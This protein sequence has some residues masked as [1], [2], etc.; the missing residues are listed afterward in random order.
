MQQGGGSG[1]G[2]GRGC[3]RWRSLGLHLALF[4]WARGWGY[5]VVGG[6]FDHYS[7]SDLDRRGAWSGRDDDWRVVDPDGFRGGE[8]ERL[9]KVTYSGQGELGLGKDGGA[10]IFLQLQP[11]REEGPDHSV[12]LC[13]WVVCGGHGSDEGADIAISLDGF[14]NIR[15]DNVGV[16]RDRG[17][18]KG[19]P[20]IEGTV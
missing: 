9:G 18:A 13:D 11:E 7:V 14:P 8:G 2:S 1:R 16:G 5:S 10:P 19:C 12:K 15:V 20:T 6:S 3:R 17:G 4:F